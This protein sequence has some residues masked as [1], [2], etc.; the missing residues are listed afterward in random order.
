MQKNNRNVAGSKHASAQ[1]QV[2][3]RNMLIVIVYSCGNFG[4]T[5]VLKHIIQP[6]EISCLFLFNMSTES[7][8]SYSDIY[9]MLNIPNILYDHY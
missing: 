5:F 2:L 8:Y 1:L 4:I 9:F 6:Q 3:L 7:R